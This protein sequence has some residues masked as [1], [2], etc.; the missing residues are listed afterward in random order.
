MLNAL[1]AGS[2]ISRL[3]SGQAAGSG[4]LASRV[5]KTAW[6]AMRERDVGHLASQDVVFPFLCL[7]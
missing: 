4:M 7:A 5:R 6:L 2:L 1:L 3:A